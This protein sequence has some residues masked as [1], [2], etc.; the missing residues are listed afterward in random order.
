MNAVV[1][2][3][4][5]DQ[6]GQVRDLPDPDPHMHS[7]I[8]RS[9]RLR[10]ILEVDE[11]TCPRFFVGQRAAA[12]RL[13]VRG[14]LLV[15]PSEV[16]RVDAVVAMAHLPDAVSSVA[17]DPSPST[18][19]RTTPEDPTPPPRGAEGRSVTVGAQG[20]G[21]QWAPPAKINNPNPANQRSQS[22]ASRRKLDS[23]RQPARQTR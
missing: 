3:R 5:V 12:G 6:A 17:P 13:H 1:F 9:R 20:T 23:T 18:A 19:T 21:S 8:R 14:S 11:G 15:T 10:Q 7:A 22:N 2:R 4:W 16:G